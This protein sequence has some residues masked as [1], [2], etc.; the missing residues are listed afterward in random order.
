MAFG[1]HLW[2]APA[3]STL[4]TSDGSA[5]ATGV[6]GDLTMRS[7][8]GNV[9]ATDTRSEHVD[10]SSSDGGVRLDLASSPTEVHATS[11][12]GNVTV[13]VPDQPGVA[14]QVSSHT[15]NGSQAV[16]VRTDPSSPRH[17]TARS[18]DGDVQVKYR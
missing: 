12:N 8:N 5:K 11:G 9:T 18:G 16:S 15:G 7:S 13:L 3:G 10:A 17:I 2:F 4:T 6:L 1:C 14:Y